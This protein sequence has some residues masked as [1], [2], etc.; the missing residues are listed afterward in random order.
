MSTVRN[1]PWGGPQGCSLGNLEYEFQTNDNTDFILE[2]DKYK[3]VDDL[4]V[5]EVI[6]LITVGLSSYNFYQHVAS[7][8]GIEQSYIPSENL[9]SQLYTDKIFK[10]TEENKMK[11]NEKKCKV[12]IFNRTRNYQ[13]TTRVQVATHL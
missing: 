13:F 8:I 7:D 9:N 6:N 12:M 5:L 3:F 11:L 10:W 2:D 4:S 1:L